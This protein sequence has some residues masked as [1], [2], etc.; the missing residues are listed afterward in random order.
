MR[1]ALDRAGWS[2]AELARQSGYGRGTTDEIVRG[3]TA[4]MDPDVVSVICRLLGIR[5]EVFLKAAGY[6]ISITPQRLVPEEM[7]ELWAAM[8]PESR[9]L[10]LGLARM[11]AITPAPMNPQS[12]PFAPCLNWFYP[13]GGGTAG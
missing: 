11:A 10:L 2:Q 8:S 7:A 3:Q 5:L 1:D 13:G 6:P 4:R 12:L 9:Q